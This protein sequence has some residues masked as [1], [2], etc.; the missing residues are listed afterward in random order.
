M[1]RWTDD[2]GLQPAHMYPHAFPN[3]NDPKALPRV[4][5]KKKYKVASVLVRFT[6][7]FHV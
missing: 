7:N 5:E 4:D 3:N 6:H 1:G 2:R